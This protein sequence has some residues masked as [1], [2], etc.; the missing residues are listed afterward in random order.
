MLLIS[1][2]FVNRDT[3]TRYSETPPYE[4]WT[5]NLGKLYQALRKEHGRCT[6]HI[7]IDQAGDVKT[8]GWV[9]L[10]RVPYEGRVR[11]GDPT[12]YLREVWVTVYT[13]YEAHRTIEREYAAIGARS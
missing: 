13:R 12:T 11:D 4:A 2:T 7:Y 1:E 8:V 9:F 5:D 6:G 10:K 3:N